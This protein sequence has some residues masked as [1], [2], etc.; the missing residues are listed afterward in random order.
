MLVPRIWG[1]MTAWAPPVPPPPSTELCINNLGEMPGIRA[2]HYHAVVGGMG[3]MRRMSLWGRS[4]DR[5]KQWIRIP[6]RPVA[7]EG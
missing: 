1:N 2:G 7:A 3:G 6:P 5:V 4:W